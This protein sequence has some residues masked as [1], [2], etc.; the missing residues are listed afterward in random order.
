LKKASILAID[1]P[2]LKWLLRLSPV[3][4]VFQI[5][6]LAIPVAPPLGEGQHNYL[7]TYSWIK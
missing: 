1:N 2:H 5:N 6:K 4:I 7:E 3:V